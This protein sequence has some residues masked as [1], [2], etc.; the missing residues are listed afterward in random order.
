MRF[1]KV[2]RVEVALKD[3]N[4]IIFFNV[5]NAYYSKMESGMWMIICE[6]ETTR[7]AREVIKTIKVIYQEE[8]Q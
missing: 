7:I 1:K 5:K 3:G 4:T 2:E 8:Q 6:Q